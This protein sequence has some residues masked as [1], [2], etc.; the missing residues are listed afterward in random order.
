MPTIEISDDYMALLHELLD[1][2]RMLTALCGSIE[3][4]N[5]A[6]PTAAEITTYAEYLLLKEAWDMAAPGEGLRRHLLKPTI[7][8]HLWQFLGMKGGKTNA[9]D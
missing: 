1:V 3:N 6:T 4:F 8:R 2:Q 7:H 9:D 5:G